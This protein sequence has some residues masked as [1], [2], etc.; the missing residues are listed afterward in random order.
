MSKSRILVCGGRDYANRD[1][2]FQVM[3]SLCQYFNPNFCVI[4]GSARGAD[5]LAKEWAE[6]LGRPV[7]CVPANWSYYGK[8]AG[9][10]RN[11]W[12]L[13]YTMPDLVVAFPGGVGTSNMIRAAKKAHIDVHRVD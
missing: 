12:M 6:S 10:I 8:S 5:L 4:Q 11:Q 7:L 13:D 2:L 3:N 9:S 1:K